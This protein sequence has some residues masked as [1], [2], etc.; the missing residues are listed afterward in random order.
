MRLP[1]NWLRDWV[2][3]E[4]T[5]SALAERLTMAGLEVEAIDRPGDAFAGVVVG[6]VLEAGRHPDADRLS[7]CRVSLGGEPIAVVCGAPNVAAGQ[8]VPFATIGTTLPNGVKLKKAKIRGQVSE[9]M[10][11]SET[12]LGIGEDASGIVVLPEEAPVGTPFATWLGVDAEVLELAVPPNRPDALSIYGLARETAALFGL[13]L[14]P[15]PEGVVERGAPAAGSIEVE[16]AD[17]QGCPR[18]AARLIRGVRIGPSPMGLAARLR[19]AGM[20][21][22]NVI[23]DITNYLMWELG[24]PLHAFD[25]ARVSEGRIVVRRARPGEQL[26]TLDGEQRRLDPEMLLITDGEH[27]LAVAGIMGG[28]G[29][30]IGPQTRD[31][32]LESACFDPVRVAVAG[33]RLA[34]LTESR[35]RFE[36]GSDPALPPRA[37]DRAAAL[38]AE[39]AGGEVAPGIVEQ[40]APGLLEPRRVSVRSG[41][42][43]AYLGAS[44]PRPEVVARLAATGFEVASEGALW[45]VTIPSWRPDATD[46]AHVAE[47]VARLWGYDE[48]GSRL[49]LSGPPPEGPTP[50]QRLRDEVAD[51]LVGLGLF[52]VVTTSLVAASMPSPAFPDAEPVIL[53]NPLSEEM[54]VLRRDLV[55]GLL[56]VV[57]HNLNRQRTDVRIFEVGSIHRVE[58]GG[59]VEEEWVV[60]LLTGG[61]SPQSWSSADARLD[62][63]DLRG[64]IESL[65]RR[66]DLAVPVM[67]PYQGALLAP[68]L[69]V[70]LTSGEGTPLG[71]AGRISRSLRAGAGIDPDV[72]AFGLRLAELEASHGKVRTFQ[73]LP[74]YPASDRDLSLLLPER[75][76]LGPLL[77]RISKERRVEQVRLTDEYS[78]A[79]IPAGWRGVTL[80]VR[81]RHPDKTMSDKEI[82]SLHKA[83]LDILEQD[84]HARLRS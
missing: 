55:P 35:R 61:R 82:D 33:G 1:L 73:G 71:W 4:G 39:L 79:Q 62:W 69:G 27:P 16:V 26:Q 53:E 40:I 58:E 24:Q 59:P 50:R 28:A 57:R 8:R 42:L 19:A 10:I 2:P 49:R 3:Y 30:E 64:L 74:R 68:G 21:P 83:L 38:M 60:A 47:E 37:A 67:V 25:L 36:R 34:L 80:S 9:G 75:L 81:Y 15:Y 20:R 45:Q 41:W 17:P 46:E 11:C 70:M 7:V 77:E 44:V 6:E 56:G 5:A 43:D 51:A 12:E 54:A 13:P 65:V 31:I 32:L 78:G 76:P 14:R 66:L 48:L 22:I 72:W 23:V 52:E 84:F 63:T 29:S 18:Y